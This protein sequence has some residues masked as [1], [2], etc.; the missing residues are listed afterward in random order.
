MDEGG[1]LDQNQLGFA[2]RPWELLGL[3]YWCLGVEQ[4]FHDAF[5][6]LSQ[7][8]MLPLIEL[9]ILS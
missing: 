4:G 1:K 9:L 5:S 3:L 8:L 6:A 7:H 2:A